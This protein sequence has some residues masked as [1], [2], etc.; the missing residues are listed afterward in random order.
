VLHHWPSDFDRAV[1]VAMIAVGMME[2]SIH[3][4]VNMITVRYCLVAAS[5]TML[6]FRLV[7]LILGELM[8]ALGVRLA[9]RKDVIL[10]CFPVLVNEMTID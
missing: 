3:Q 6:V 1:V 7:F 2:N 9:D 10:N 8:A 4:V 5:G